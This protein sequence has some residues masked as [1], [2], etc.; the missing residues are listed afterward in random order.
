MTLSCPM[1]MFGMIFSIATILKM[2]SL[3]LTHTWR[4][5]AKTIMLE[6]IAITMAK[7][8]T[9]ITSKISNTRCGLESGLSPLMS[10]LCG[11]VDSTIV[12]L[13]TSL[14]ASGSTVPTA[15]YLH[16]ITLTLTEL[17][18]LLVPTVKVIE[19]L[20]TTASALLTPPSSVMLMC[21]FLVTAQG[22]SLIT[23]SRVSSFGLSG[24][25]SSQS[26]TT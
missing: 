12:T 18:P 2:S 8:F 22:T 5:T 3:I 11:S 4:G 16:P 19:L 20:F 17:Q 14:T 7:D 25:N 26:G 13:S 1:Q 9:P 10:V 24:T 15:I 23:L 21:R 6:L